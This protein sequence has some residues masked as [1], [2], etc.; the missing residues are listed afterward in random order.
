MTFPTP[1]LTCASMTNQ[2]SKSGMH[3]EGKE[4]F[5][6]SLAILILIYLHITHF[7][8]VGC[9]FNEDDTGSNYIKYPYC[10]PYQSKSLV[11]H[12]IRV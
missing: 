10:Y 3:D 4:A 11:H 1:S 12:R 6:A 5:F 9:P 8:H 2:T 7:C